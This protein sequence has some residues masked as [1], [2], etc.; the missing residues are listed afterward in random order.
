MDALAQ[1]SGVSGHQRGRGIELHDTPGE[2]SA[3]RKA[4]GRPQC[5]QLPDQRIQRQCNQTLLQGAWR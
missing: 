3:Q 1:Q 2:T 5:L 4:Q